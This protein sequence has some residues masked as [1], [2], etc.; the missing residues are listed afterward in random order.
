MAKKQT[1]FSGHHD[2]KGKYKEIRAFINNWLL[3][4][5]LYCNTCGFPYFPLE[6]AC[7]DNPRIG[8]NIQ[9]CQALLL[10]IAAERKC[11]NNEFG[12]NK[13]KTLRQAVSLPPDLMQKL[14]KFC[15]EKLG[16]KLFVNSKDLREFMK[17]FPQFTT[18]SRI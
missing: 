2:E 12:S 1:A 17:H 7:C 5:A 13:D 18:C 6:K 11:N 8:K 10:Q 3:D 14:E 15:K 9:H 4:P 16:E